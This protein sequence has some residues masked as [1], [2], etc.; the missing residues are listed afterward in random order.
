MLTCRILCIG[1]LK[2]EYWRLACAEYQKRLTPFCR[3]QLVQLDE[4]R[5]PEKP[6]PA[7]IE[8]AV[9]QEGSRILQ[10]VPAGSTLVSLCIEGAP[11]SSQQLSQMIEGWKNEGRADI[12]FAI[13]GSWGLSDAVKQAS[14]FRLSMSAMTFPHQ[15]ARVMLLEQLYRAAQIA[16]G[17]KYHK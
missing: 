1:K 11:L 14:H 5:V 8:A 2:E 15:L 13:G 16:A 9:R 10:A 17:G 7:Q 12:S 4:E 3:L 6:S